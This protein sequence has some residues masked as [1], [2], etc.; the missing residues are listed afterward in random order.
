MTQDDQAANFARLMKQLEQS[1]PNNWGDIFKLLDETKGSVPYADTGV[2]AYPELDI[3]ANTAFITFDYGI[4]GVS[5]EIGKYARALESVFESSGGI[6]LHFIG[7]DFYQQADAVLDPDWNRYA[8]S[9]IN[10][11]SKWDDGKWF[12]ALYYDDLPT[13]SQISNRLAK[14]I[15]NQS[16]DIT[17]KLG[18]YIIE[19]QVT[20]LV[21]VNIASNPGNLALSIAVALVTEGLGTFV[22]NSNHDF[23]W[24]G[25]KSAKQRK[26]GDQPGIRDHFFRNE[27]NEAF[28]TLFQVV[29]PWNGKRWLQV[30]INRLQSRKLIEAFYFSPRMVSELSTAVSDVFFEEYTFE[31]VQHARQRMGLILSDGKGKLHSKAISDHLE[32]LPAWMN[33]QKPCIL[34]TRSGLTV[35]PTNKD[36]LL[37]L[38]PTRVIARK[39][40]ERDV[41]LISALF[42]HQPFRLAFENNP[43]MQVVLHITG[44]TP[45]EHQEDLETV[46]NAYQD[47]LASLPAA[48]GERFFLAFSVGNEEHPSF[49]AHQYE[50]MTI[51]DIYRM[52][53]VVVFP[54]EIEGRG[55]PIIEA[56]ASGV[57]LICSRYSPEEVFASVIGEGLPGEKQ[58]RYVLF[59]EEDFSTDFLDEVTA[60]LISTGSGEELRKHN[61]AAVRSRYSQAVLTDTFRELLGKLQ[62]IR[63]TGIGSS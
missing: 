35:N 56:S 39:R 23:Y 5:I 11:W 17:R 16:I 45:I 47:V 27:A 8:I 49:H 62:D 36:Y 18:S 25:G 1:D 14:E 9:G 54:S 21:P 63:D 55:L 48:I 30:N 50:R 19:N 40:I 42:D 46:L 12:N 60:L 37:F 52:A 38:Q 34:G 53:T 7:G 22:I 29:Y 51:E 33:D 41:H 6:D 43:R 28:F 58:I 44:P 4:D 3:G 57:P 2:A 10:G 24:E 59:P 31:D 32:N 13:G 26:P 15:F 61:R 20:L